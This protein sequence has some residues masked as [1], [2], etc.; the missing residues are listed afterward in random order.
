MRKL[1]AGAPVLGV[2]VSMSD[3]TVTEALADS[4]DFV[5]IDQE[6][7]PLSTGDVQG[8]IMAT[9]GSPATPIVRVPWNDHVMIKRIL[10][11]GAAGII[12]PMVRTAAEARRAVEACLYPPAGIRGYGPRRPS[13]YG[14]HGGVAFVRAA[15]ASVIPILQ[16]EH[17]DA[18]EQI[19]DIL[20]VAGIASLVFGPNDLAGSMGLLGEPQHPRVEAA[21]DHV[22]ARARAAGVFVGSGMGGSAEQIAAAFNRGMHWS[23]AGVDY[24]F[25]LHAVDRLLD[26][27][28]QRLP[29]VAAAA[30]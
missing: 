21:I 20:A 18:V 9:K 30:D 10:D 24:A 28:R 2:G 14:R 17:V 16:I 12:V 23:L 1:Y 3:P 8:H 4:V 27:V 29:P 5:W 22:I 26:E 13:N 19:D 11:A 7:N 25:M 6:H 15:N